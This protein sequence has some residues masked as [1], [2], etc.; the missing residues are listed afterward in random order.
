MKD[1]PILKKEINKNMEE[2][3]E[4]CM[5]SLHNYFFGEYAEKNVTISRKERNFMKKL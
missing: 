5:F 2:L 3:A 1:Y 4:Y